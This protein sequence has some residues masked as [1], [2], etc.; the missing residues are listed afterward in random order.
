MELHEKIKLGVQK[1]LS[2]E[3]TLTE[4]SKELKVES[5]LINAELNKMGYFLHGGQKPEQVINL[6]LACDY[7]VKNI[8]KKI[9]LSK[10]STMFSISKIS[11]SKR[12]KSLGY[13]IINRQKQVKFNQYIFDS[14]DTEEKAYWLG[15]IFADGNISSIT[16]NK[17]PVYRFELSLKYND[18]EHLYKFNTFMQYINNNVKI[19]DSKCNNKVFKRCRWYIHNK[20]LW[21]ILNNYGCVPN[22]SLILE[23]PEESIFKDKSLIRHFIRGYWDGDGCLSWC[24]KNHTQPCI[25]VV[26]TNQFLESIKKYLNLNAK[27]QAKNYDSTTRQFSISRKQAF[28]IIKYLYSNSTIYLDRKYKIYLEYCRLYE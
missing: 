10:I 1:Y 6:K 25:E 14:I 24:D 23:F 4:I 22:K 12:L 27:L 28:N 18:Y 16:L 8:D 15:F 7:Y 26:G 20:Y 9:S 5:K 21:N 17:K 3:G 11:L 13:E 2:K 19:N